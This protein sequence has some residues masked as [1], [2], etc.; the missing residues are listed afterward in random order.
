MEL[1]AWDIDEAI[2]YCRSRGQEP[3]VM[4]SRSN[5]GIESG[6]KRVVRYT[7]QK[8]MPMLIWSLFQRDT[9]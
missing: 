2:A 1:L 6:D 4:E 9:Q 3:I 5:K 8:G 7:F